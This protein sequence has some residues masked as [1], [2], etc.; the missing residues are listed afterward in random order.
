[1]L[2]LSPGE[3]QFLSDGISQNIRNDGRNRLDYRPIILETGVISQAN[4]SARI[5][6]DG[7]DV[8]I[9]IKA[10]LGEPR[11]VMNQGRVEVFVECCP[12]ASPEFEGRGGAA[13]NL[14]LGRVT[15]RYLNESN[16]LNLKSLCLVPGKQCWVLSVDALVLGSTGN[17]FDAISIGTRAALLNTRIP[18]VSVVECDDGSFDLELDTEKTF[19]IDVNNVPVCVTLTRI[20][21]DHIVDASLEEEFCSCCRIAFAVNKKGNLTTIQKGSGTVTRQQ[22]QKMMLDA[23]VVGQKIIE[24]LDSNLESERLIKKKVGFFT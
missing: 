5:L 11:D 7:T 20:G 22:L 24:V 13:L 2:Q 18:V 6:L 16:S 12:S 23:T 14:E 8:L 1:M 10:E 3:I 9:G 4:G 17:L 21:N 19:G 15:E